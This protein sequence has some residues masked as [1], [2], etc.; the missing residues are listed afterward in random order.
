MIHTQELANN[1]EL[2][3]QHIFAV[4][5]SSV[6]T[7]TPIPLQSTFKAVAIEVD[8]KTLDETFEMLRKD[9][10][11]K[12]EFGDVIWKSGTELKQGLLFLNDFSKAAIGRE[13]TNFQFASEIFDN[14]VPETKS[15]QRKYGPYTLRTFYLQAVHHINSGESVV[16]NPSSI[17]MNEKN[18]PD[19]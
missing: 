6:K 15:V 14:Q 12:K 18:K 13:K 19:L 4:K 17:E 7:D 1:N 10:G 8:I 16:I 9:W 5:D 3:I 2:A 11:I